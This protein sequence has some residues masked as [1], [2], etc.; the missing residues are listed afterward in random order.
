M[1][2]A[3]RHTTPV[4]GRD[5]LSVLWDSRT[6]KPCYH[7]QKDFHITVACPVRFVQRTREALLG[8]GERGRE[9]DGNVYIQ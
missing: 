2:S 8:G 7:F 4:W 9:I 1:T 3:L 5:L 6:Y